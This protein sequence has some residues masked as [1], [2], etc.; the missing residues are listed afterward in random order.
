MCIMHDPHIRR[1]CMGVLCEGT[2]LQMAGTWIGML[3]TKVERYIWPS[4]RASSNQMAQPG[5]HNDAEIMCVI[6]ECWHQFSS[7][8]PMMDC[9][10]ILYKSTPNIIN[11]GHQTHFS[12]LANW[13]S[14]IYYGMSG[15]MQFASVFTLNTSTLQNRVNA[16]QA[17]PMSW[18]FW[19]IDLFSSD[20]IF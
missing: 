4:N 11:Y 16:F 14:N 20:T 13:C 15:M 8:Q 7:Q 10:I 17:L 12:F 5:G 6:C 3:E 18:S 19:I 9:V 1:R 2:W